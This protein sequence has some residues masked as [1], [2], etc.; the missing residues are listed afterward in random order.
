MALLADV[1][2]SFFSFETTVEKQYGL[3]CM[4]GNYQEVFI[5]IA[6]VDDAP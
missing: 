3:E 4:L 5:S 1:Q 2:I 6:S